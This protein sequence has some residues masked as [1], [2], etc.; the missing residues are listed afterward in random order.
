MLSRA[1]LLLTLLL[2]A[3]EAVTPAQQVAYEPNR[4]IN[5]WESVADTL[6]NAN[7]RHPWQFVGTQGDMIRLYATGRGI[8]IDLQA[9]DGSQL[10]SGSNIEVTLP[11][12]GT[13]TATLG[14]SDG[15]SSVEYNLILE[16]ADQANP[17]LPT[18]VPTAT[19]E[20]S[21]T[22]TLTPAPT[23]TLLHAGLG[24]LIGKLDSGQIQDSSF[25]RPDEEHVYTFDGVR[26]Q[27]VTVRM[28]RAGGDTDPFIALHDPAGNLLAIDDN[29]GG[30]GSALLRNVPLPV[31]GEYALQV[32]GS[33]ILGSYRLNVFT[34]TDP[35]PVT[36][37]LPELT[38]TPTTTPT[39]MST[40]ARLQPFSPLESSIDAAGGFQRFLLFVEEGDLLT[41]GVLPIDT[42]AL[43]PEVEL[44]NGEG[45]IVITETVYTSNANGAALIDALP[46]EVGGPHQVIVRA[47]GQGTGTF[48]ISY[49]TGTAYENVRRGDI[50]PDVAMNGEV[51]RRGLGD[52]WRLFLNAGDTITVAVEARSATF[53]PA[54]EV[55]AP[56]GTVIASDDNSGGGR[57]PALNDVTVPEGGAYHVRVTGSQAQSSGVYTVVWRYL[58]VAPTPTSL[59]GTVRIMSVTDEMPPERV[60]RTFPFQGELGQRVEIQIIAKDETG[61]DMVAALIAPDGTEIALDDDSGGNLNP[62][63]RAELPMTGTYQVRVNDYIG[64]PGEFDVQVSLLY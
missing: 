40:T 61:L 38:N 64:T 20:V 62:L 21:P 27:Y 39:P 37:V 19:I 12:D 2:A 14:L 57:N 45:T 30:E 46:I 48:I 36:P 25:T 54:V 58:S 15:E 9:P 42:A 6:P 26:G 4:I 17:T 3:C 47:E 63:I 43:R 23:A 24:T 49:G 50:E 11:A 29:T 60:Y 53:D 8:E 28:A 44:I 32:S 52:V 7:M 16:Y 10:A 51:A 33:G 34:T 31:D 59:P 35:Q 18:A 41:L 56:D 22:T 1:I 5:Y 13:Y 55:L